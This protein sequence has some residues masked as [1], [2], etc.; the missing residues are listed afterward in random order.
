VR[1]IS[2][3]ALADWRNEYTLSGNALFLSKGVG[4]KDQI[5]KVFLQFIGQCGAVVS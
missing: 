3:L 5:L 1:V 4:T 2:T